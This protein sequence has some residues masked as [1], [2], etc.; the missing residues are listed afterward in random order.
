ME[1]L[2]ITIMVISAAVA[3][4]S[5]KRWRSAVKEQAK[6]KRVDSER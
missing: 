6:S 4:W 3:A 2:L 5:L 1:I